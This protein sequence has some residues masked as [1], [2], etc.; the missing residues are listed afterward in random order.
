MLNH[1]SKCMENAIFFFSTKFVVDC[2]IDRKCF[3][4]LNEK[5]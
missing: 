3:F 2:T 5:V 4:L 1:S